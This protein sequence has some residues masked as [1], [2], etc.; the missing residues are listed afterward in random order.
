MMKDISITREE[1][2]ALKGF[3]LLLIIL[4][5]T[6]AL[7]ENERSL[8]YH[9]LYAFHV[10]AF[11][12]LPW[13][14]PHKERPLKTYIPTMAIR[15]IVPYTFFYLVAYLLF[16]ITT[17]APWEG[18]FNAY[19]SLNWQIIRDT[20]GLQSLWFLPTFFVFMILTQTLRN[21][22]GNQ[23]GPTIF[24]LSIAVL[25]HLYITSNPEYYELYP[26]TYNLSLYMSSAL[27][28]LLLLQTSHLRWLF[29]ISL[30]CFLAFSTLYLS[31]ERPYNHTPIRIIMGVCAFIIAYSFKAHLSKNNILKELGKY[32]LSIYLFHIFII[33]VCEKII[34]FSSLAGI[35]T[36]FLATIGAYFLSKLLYSH[37]RLRQM[38]FPSSWED[39]KNSFSIE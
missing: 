13:I 35:V 27:L 24:A 36:Y 10:I 6:K 23:T 25:V 28:T 31:Y 15:M 2:T 17:S 19:F 39:F 9:W 38:L 14:Y 30:L 11:F 8:L 12:I 29:Y 32:S 18:L 4:G 7:V 37:V 3:F 33:K 20:I 26:W 5:H 1:S 16:H 21:F 22:I 34:G